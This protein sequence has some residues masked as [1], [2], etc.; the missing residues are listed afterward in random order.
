MSDPFLTH[1]ADSFRPMGLAES[2][3]A[4]WFSGARQELVVVK[5]NMAIYMAFTGWDGGVSCEDL[6]TI[7]TALLDA[8]GDY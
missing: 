3:N 8:S 2:F 5:E 7:Y 4:V 6:Q 1:G